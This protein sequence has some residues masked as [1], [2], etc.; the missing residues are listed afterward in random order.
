VT[1]AHTK[2][3]KK[4]DKFFCYKTLDVIY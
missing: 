1:V 2:M 4:I 3:K